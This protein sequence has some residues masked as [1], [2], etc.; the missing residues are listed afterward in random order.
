MEGTSDEDEA[1][2]GEGA[3]SQALGCLDVKDAFL[4][5]PHEKP[6]KVNLRG[7]EFLAKRNLPG[8]RVGA[9]AWFDFFIEYLTEEFN[10]KFSAE[11]PCLGRNEKGIILTHVDDVISTPQETQSTSMKSRFE[12][13]GDEFNFLWVGGLWIQPDN[14]CQQMLKAYEEQIGLVKLQQLPA[15]D[16]IQMEDKPEA[17]HERQK[18]SVKSYS[19]VTSSLEEGYGVFSSV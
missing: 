18:I 13:I 6:L 2:E 7:E 8:Q 14:Y 5:V 1:R 9:K 17:L 3:F 12:R 11:C 4:Q 10:Y 16:S 15:D 19:Y